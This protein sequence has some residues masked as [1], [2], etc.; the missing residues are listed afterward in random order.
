MKDDR[1]GKQDERLLNKLTCLW[2]PFLLCLFHPLIIIPLFF[3]I[4]ALYFANDANSNKSFSI[5]LQIIATLLASIVGGIII[6]NIK[7]N[8][9]ED[10]LTKKGKSAVRN[11]ALTRS[12]LKDIGHRIQD[13]AS[14]E[15][16]SNLLSWMEEEVT[17]AIQEWNDILPDLK[18]IE[19][20]YIL[21]QDMEVEL[22]KI[23]QEKDVLTKQY[24]RAQQESA[25]EKN[26]LKQLIEEKI[27]KIKEFEE[28]SRSLRFETNP[29]IAS[30]TLSG[31]SG[32][33]WEQTKINTNYIKC[34]KCGNY[35]IR[36]NKD[37]ALFSVSNFDLCD[38][39]KE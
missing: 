11:L 23:E 32:S 21:L 19:E 7:E 5:L 13:K 16:L 34:R 15:E 4:V 30:G 6:D 1:I 17:N 18:K 39:C 26:R 3:I 36:E 35:F 22:K 14:A 10:I 37:L 38:K 9:K 20:S 33:Y 24:E 25:A 28:N 29:F 27:S 8:L 2:K 31:L 12:K